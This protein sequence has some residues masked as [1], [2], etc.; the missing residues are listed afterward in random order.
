MISL[1]TDV[2][3]RVTGRIAA[4][5]LQP[6]DTQAH[7]INNPPTEKG[8]SHEHQPSHFAAGPT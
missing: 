7:P 3:T 4:E 2:Y 1:P 6:P 8:V 5:Y